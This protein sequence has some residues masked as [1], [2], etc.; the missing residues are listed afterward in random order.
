MK[1][2]IEKVQDPTVLE[3]LCAFEDKPDGVRRLAVLLPAK[4]KQVQACAERFKLSNA[5]RK[6]LE[7][8]RCQEEKLTPFIQESALRAFLFRYGAETALDHLML[9]WAEKGFTGIGPKEQKLLDDIHQWQN[10]PINFPVQGRDLLARG[11]VAG[12][13]L[14]QTL[15]QLENWW[16]ENGCSDDK[17]SCLKQLPS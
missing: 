6:R 9:Y 3:M 17:E 10:A 14:G 2:L 12:P 4:I 5:Q 1:H 13:E 16:C 11:Y 15:K 8:A 7:K